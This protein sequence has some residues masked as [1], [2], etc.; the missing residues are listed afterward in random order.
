[1]FGTLTVAHYDGSL[2]FDADHDAVV[3]HDDVRSRHAS[4]AA[5]QSPPHHHSP[6]DDDLITNQLAIAIIPILHHHCNP[7]LESCLYTSSIPNAFEYLL[8]TYD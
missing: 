8:L 3:R 6:L 5:V 1:M 4:F 2:R 7:L